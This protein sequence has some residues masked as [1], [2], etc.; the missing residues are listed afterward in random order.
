ML[1]G[2]LQKKKDIK[3]SE[4][5]TR[6]EKTEARYISR[7]KSIVAKFEKVKG[8]SIDY[9]KGIFCEHLIQITSG[10]TQSNLRQIKASCSFYASSLGFEGLALAISN[11]PIEQAT[12]K[13]QGNK[14]SSQKKK[15]ISFEEE[16][17][18]H[19]YILTEI[20]S[21]NDCSYWNKPTFLFF[22]AGLAVGLRP[23]E[24]QSSEILNEPTEACA[25]L[26]PPILKVKN[27]KS[28]N[29]RSYGE[30]RYIGISTLKA[31]DM[32]MIKE[33]LIQ[34]RA[35]KNK[36][37]EPI[38]WDEY[39]TGISGRLYSITKR[40]FPRNKK[41]PSL[42]SCRHQQI[43]NLKSAGYSLVEIAC[44]SGHLTDVTAS[45]HYGKRRYGN[46]DANLPIANP[47]DLGKIKKMFGIKTSAPEPSM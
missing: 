25:G 18:I 16:Q 32:S 12:S 46:K 6:I 42:Y 8:H 7:A 26:V 17:A 34:A 38:S 19:N 31:S 29:G 41:R 3:L 14:T 27:G 40:L 30:Y 43:A 15:F 23:I 13:S 33:A 10:K 37:G 44:L 11:L 39:Y 5:K 1:V 22:K 4:V 35:P 36:E 21:G 24:W 45:E 20:K 9:D 2:K 47:V 28:T